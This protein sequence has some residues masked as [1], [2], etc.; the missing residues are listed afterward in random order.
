MALAPEV[1]VFKALVGLN[2]S[3]AEEFSTVNPVLVE[4]ALYLDTTNQ[5]LKLGDGVKT[6]NDTDV[7]YD[8]A[9]L[10]Q[11][12]T[13]TITWVADIAARDAVT[14]DRKYGLVM[15][16]DASG[17]ATVTDETK[18]T[19][20]YTYSDADSAWV[21]VMEAES[22]DVDLSDYFAMSTNTADDITEGTTHLFLTAAERAEIAALRTELDEAK[23]AVQAIQDDEDIVRYS[24]TVV[25]QGL[26]AQEIADIQTA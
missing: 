23:E 21:K 7:Y 16:I 5:I 12:L 4:N 13:A 19:A 11:A 6:W 26:N 10:Q 25:I 3:T 24:H 14:D 2:A 15:V 8:P 9:Q 22:M 1:K 20:G 17:D 18:K